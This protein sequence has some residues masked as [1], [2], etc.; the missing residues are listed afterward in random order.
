MSCT[1]CASPSSFL[2][3]VQIFQSQKLFLKDY[4]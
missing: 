1:G 3:S 4:F 2:S